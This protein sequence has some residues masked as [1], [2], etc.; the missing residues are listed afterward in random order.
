[1][2]LHK[3]IYDS[4]G[5]WVILL[6][7]WQNLLLEK[8]FPPHSLLIQKEPAAQAIKEHTPGLSVGS[9][10]CT[11][12]SPI[13]FRCA[14]LWSGSMGSSSSVFTYFSL[15]RGGP[16][17]QYTKYRLANVSRYYA[18]GNH[19]KLT[20]PAVCL[21]TPLPPISPDSNPSAFPHTTRLKASV[22]TETSSGGFNCHRTKKEGLPFYR[23]HLW[24]LEARR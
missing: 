22:S 9:H 3:Y 20:P 1:M 19:A 6:Q 8:S 2:G 16:S 11:W 7:H 17:H 24:N 4:E 23:A 10:Q 18:P 13:W 5:V 21:Q 12:C 15:S 14:P